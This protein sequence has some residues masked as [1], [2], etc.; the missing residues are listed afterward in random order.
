MN[1]HTKGFTLVEMVVTIVVLSVMLFSVMMI[2]TEGLKIWWV[3]RNYVELRANGRYAL[4]KMG[5]EFREA[6]FVFSQSGNQSAISFLSD[7]DRDG[8]RE[9]IDYWLSG[10]MLARSEDGGTP[11]PLAY[12]M[13]TITFNWDAPLLTVAMELVRGAET[14]NLQTSVTAKC[15]PQ[16]QL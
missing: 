9:K 10:N 14:V 7:I 5:L 3:N 11:W 8:N 12:D 15:I 1:R 16:S 4:W 13:N 2:L 6:E